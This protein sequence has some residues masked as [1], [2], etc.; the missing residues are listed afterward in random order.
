MGSSKLHENVQL[1]SSGGDSESKELKTKVLNIW[2]LRIFQSSTA[3]ILT[4]G[5]LLIFSRISSSDKEEV[6]G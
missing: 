5:S 2:S 1:D 4:T 6:C 3:R